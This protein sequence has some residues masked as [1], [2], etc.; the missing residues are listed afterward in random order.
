MSEINIQS[1]EDIGKL[2]GCHIHSARVVKEGTVTRFELQVSHITMPG[3][4]KVVVFPFASISIALGAG[5]I[6]A[7]LS[8]QTY[9]V[10]KGEEG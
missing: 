6:A 10:P 4:V 7:G 9:D 8:F 3:V 5:T 2:V 1:T